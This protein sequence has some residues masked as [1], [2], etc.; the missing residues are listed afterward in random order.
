VAVALN[1]AVSLA[2][3]RHAQHD[4]NVRSAFVHMVGDAVSSAGVLAAGAAVLWTGAAVWDAAV[5]LAIGVFIVWSGWEVTHE[6]LTILLEGTPKG[7]ELHEVER[8]IT[9]VPGVV[10]IHDLHVW[11]LGA[12]AHALAAHVVVDE[13]GGAVN[14]EIADIVHQVKVALAARH[15]ITHATLE[16]HCCDAL[17]AEGFAPCEFDA[18][19]PQTATAA[20]RHETG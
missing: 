18:L 14:R 4:V 9:E 15:A 12:Q 17:E 5:S 8:T 13:A 16:T 19:P 2:L 1:L 11:T 10:S 6:A 20:H 3:R 7:M